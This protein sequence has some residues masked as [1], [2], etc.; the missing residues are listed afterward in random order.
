MRTAFIAFLAIVTLGG[1]ASADVGLR[2]TYEVVGVEE[3]DMLKMRAGP[4]TGYKIILGLPNG[5][6]VRLYDCDQTGR[7]YCQIWCLG[8]LHAAA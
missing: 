8:G 1:F 2:G 6:I 4:G 5:T 7:S 3:D